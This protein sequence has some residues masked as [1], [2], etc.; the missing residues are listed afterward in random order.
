[1]ILFFT[2][3]VTNFKLGFEKQIFL[4]RL[5]GSLVNLKGLRERRSLLN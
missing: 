2:L 4:F 5:E 3:E 1:M